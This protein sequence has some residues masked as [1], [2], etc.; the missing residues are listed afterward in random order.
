MWFTEPF[1][2]PQ[3]ID[4]S[5]AAT[6]AVAAAERGVVEAVAPNT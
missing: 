5:A 6:S 3:R 2:F 4:E 1:S